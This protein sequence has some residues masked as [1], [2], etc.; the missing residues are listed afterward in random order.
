[1]WRYSFYVEVQLLCGGTHVLFIFEA[2]HSLW[3][4][5]HDLPLPVSEIEPPALLLLLERERE[6][7][8]ERW[9]INMWGV[10]FSPYMRLHSPQGSRGR[11]LGDFLDWFAQT[12][13]SGVCAC[14]VVVT[15]TPSPHPPSPHHSLSSSTLPTSFPPSSLSLSTGERFVMVIRIS[16]VYSSLPNPNSKFPLCTYLYFY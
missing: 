1:M 8:R 3:Y 16:L 4:S 10:F 2:N 13:S 5:D 14:S 11:E 12:S 9:I 7:E 15:P 6:R